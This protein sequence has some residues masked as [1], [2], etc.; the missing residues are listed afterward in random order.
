MTTARMLLWG[1]VLSVMP[2][3]LQAQFTYTVSAGAVTITGYSGSDGIINVPSTIDGYPVTTIGDYAFS[4]YFYG[5]SPTMVVIPNSVTSLGSGICYGCSSLTNA[6][7][8][9]GVLSGL[10]GAFG[11]CRSLVAINVNVFNP[12]YS[13]VNGILF[14]KNQ[15]ALLQYPAGNGVQNYV[16]PNSISR[17]GNMAFNWCTSLTNITIPNSVTNIGLG[18]FY[19][20]S[21]LI[22][23]VIPDSVTSVG[24]D[25]FYNCQHLSDAVI[26]RSINSIS[27]GMF[28]YCLSLKTI[29]IPTNITSIESS[30]FEG[31]GLTNI[32]IPNSV[33]SI[34]DA[35]F[36]YTALTSVVIPTSITSIASQLF[37]VCGNL[38]NV[39]LPNTITNIGS[40]AFY[41]CVNL[42]TI[43]IPS[44]VASIGDASFM[45]CNNLTAV[46][47][48]GNAPNVG[49]DLLKYT[50][51][52][53]Y[54]L[55]G[56]TGWNQ[57]LSSVGHT[58]LLWNPQI[59]N[60]ASFGVQNNQFGFNITGTTNIPIVVEA[61]TNLANAV[62]TPLQSCLVT[63]GSIHFSDSQY[64]NLPSRI[65]RIRSP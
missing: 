9:R 17:I 33:T 3:A 44:Q 38:T 46:F 18:A 60:D 37:D 45:N 48:Q 20:C 12:N 26:P 58:G 13:S 30:A 32:S 8:G 55:Q 51:A 41:N 27:M 7:I 34:G 61:C 15:T 54:Y 19:S 22:S 53:V 16:I 57:F 42:Q 29:L 47:F 28:Q 56:T 14:D 65:Y 36:E 6:S 5:I 63:N 24:M 21:G 11:Y 49:V 52:I 62:W 43:T 2:F 10:E 39:F 1:F 4:E 35:A 40:L 59:L 23:V 50:P 31:C 25:V 64:P